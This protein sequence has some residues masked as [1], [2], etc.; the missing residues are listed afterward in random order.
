MK[1]HMKT[2]TYDVCHTHFVI[3]TGE[4]ALWVNRKYGLPYVITA[5]GSDVEGH[6]HKI[7]MKIMHRLLRSSWRKIVN[8][9]EGV[10]APS[11]YLQN[12]MK[13]RYDQGKY[14]FIPNG[15]DI[16]KYVQLAVQGK[17]KSILVM[18]RLQRHKNVQTILRAL[19]QTDLTDWTVDILGDGPYSKELERLVLEF[20]LTSFVKF[21][22]WIDNGSR[23]QMYYLRKSSIYITASYFENCPMS[24]IETIAAGCYPLLS[25]IPAHRQLVSEDEYYFEANDIQGLSFKLQALINKIDKIPRNRIDIS[26]YDWKNIIN[27]YEDILYK[28]SEKKT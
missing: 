26:R 9:S 14:S 7:Y 20:K 5:H 28:A 2:H 1:Q 25:D 23:E 24:V 21:H 27:Q 16:V 19:A 17:E 13:S 15:L 11:V 18:G 4:A 6:N 8:C 12:L 10:I 3:P 22:G